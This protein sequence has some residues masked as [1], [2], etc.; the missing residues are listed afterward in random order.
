MSP[1]IEDGTVRTRPARPHTDDVM[2]TRPAINR[3]NVQYKPHPLKFT[4]KTAKT[5]CEAAT[6]STDTRIFNSVR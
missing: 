3:R 2:S 5:P 4:D 1:P 6:E